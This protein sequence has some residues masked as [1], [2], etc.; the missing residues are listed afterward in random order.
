ME[1]LKQKVAKL[2]G[3]DIQELAIIKINNTIVAEGSLRKPIRFFIDGSEAT[4]NGA[5]SE[6]IEIVYGVFTNFRDIV[7]GFNSSGLMSER[8][9]ELIEAD[10]ADDLRDNQPPGASIVLLSKENTPD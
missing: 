4:T 7:Y 8:L 5:S 6:S 10:S 3:L 2:A 9:L 1:Q